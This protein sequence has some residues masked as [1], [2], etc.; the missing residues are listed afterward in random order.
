[1]QPQAVTLLFAYDAW[2]TERILGQA[3]K[4]SEAELLAPRPF[5]QGSLRDTLVHMVSAMWIWRTRCQAGQSPTHFLAA[6]DFADIA[7]VQRRWQTESTAI[8]DYVA[9]L[10]MADLSSTFHYQ[11]TR[12]NR[13]QDVLWSILAHVINHSTQHRTEAAA[14]LTT[15]GYSPGDLDLI[16]YLRQQ[17][18]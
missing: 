14:I 1:M 7:A 13:H 2:A 18:A 8:R 11:D 4:V 15:L 5:G 3:A 17:G 10:S 6:G 12:G 9:G 16:V